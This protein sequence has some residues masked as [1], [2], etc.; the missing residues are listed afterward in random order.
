MRDI[1]LLSGLAVAGAAAGG[2][3]L[4]R[5]QRNPD[6]RERRRRLMINSDGRLIDGM[7]LDVRDGIVYFSYSWRGV[8]YEAAQDVRPLSSLVPDP[9]EQIVGPVTLKFLPRDPSNSIVLC[10]HWSGFAKRRNGQ[11]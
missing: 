9:P 7:I 10:E 3:L 6:E 8:D 1:A 2:W 5:L 4:L 11:G